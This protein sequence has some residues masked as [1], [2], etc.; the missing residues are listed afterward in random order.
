M[1]EII[2]GIYQMQIPIHNNPLG[3]TNTYLVRGTGGYLLIDAG[4]NSGEA[5][6]SMKD[7]LDELGLTFRDITRILATHI[8]GDHYGLVHTLKQHT[9]AEVIIHRL[10]KDVLL[11]HYTTADDTLSDIERVFL[12]NGAPGD[13]IPMPGLPARDRQRLQTPVIPDTTL[14]GG[15]TISTGEFD[16]LVIWTPGHAPGH[17]C[18][19]EPVNKLLFAGDHVL[20]VITPNISLLP[21]AG[22]NPLGDFMKSLDTLEALDVE[23]VLPAHESEYTDL[24]KRI[25]EI[26]YHNSQRNLEIKETLKDGPKTAYQVSSAITWVPESGGIRYKD[27]PPMDKRMAVLETL[28]HL[29][30]MLVD[31]EVESCSEEGMIYYRLA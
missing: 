30:A 7:Q 26:I 8:H 28:A 18:L 3:H 25:H 9:D 22:D 20:P 12:S 21:Y 13:E 31:R 29:K 16:L 4:W 15:E 17:I 27:L 10:E 24:R 2:P 14:E 1:I 19:Y 11:R 6:A 5:L 23:R